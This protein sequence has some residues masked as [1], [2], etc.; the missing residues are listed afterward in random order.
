MKII[1]SR[2]GFDSKYGRIPS[3]I[4]P[5]GTLLSL[6]IHDDKDMH[7]KF[8]QLFY[9]NK[10]YDRIINELMGDADGVKSK[11]SDEIYCHLDP[12]IRQDIIKDRNPK[13]RAAFGQSG[14]A[15]GHLSNKCVKE[16]DIF[17]FFGWFKQAELVDNK[18]NYMHESQDLHIIYGY[19]QV[20]EM[21]KNIREINN[22]PDY[23]RSHSH[24]TKYHI[25]QG[26]NCI[27]VASEKLS[28]NKNR[29]GSDVLKCKPNL[30]LTKEGMTRSKW[31]LTNIFENLP[32]TY[33][34]NNSIRDGYFQSAHI[35]QEFI[36]EGGEELLNWTKDIIETN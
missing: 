24:S 29:K 18:F 4:L 7:T 15:Q 2:K 31:R 17:L 5:D 16:G 23:I 33:H 22:L 13:W 30:V 34:N 25:E 12:D 21:Y 9:E 11:Y 32:I 20:G 36:I 27:Y 26:S 19:L 28:F 6:P 14:A 1:L 10:S 35:G 8:S 3:P